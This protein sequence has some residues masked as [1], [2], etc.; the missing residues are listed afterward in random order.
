VTE[1]IFEEKNSRKKCEK[2]DKTNQETKSRSI[3]FGER[4]RVDLV[5]EEG[6]EDDEEEAI[7]AVVRGVAETAGTEAAFERG[8]ARRGEADFEDDFE[9]DDDEVESEGEE[10]RERGKRLR[11]DMY[12]ADKTS[13]SS[14]SCGV[15]QVAGEPSAHS[16]R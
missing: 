11:L 6:Y 8:E 15:C 2:C 4:V 12:L 13:K 9:R 5:D 1:K 10:E 14:M 3:E 7:E 16:T